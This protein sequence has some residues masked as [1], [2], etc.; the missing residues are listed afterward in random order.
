MTRPTT[1][2]ESDGKVTVEGAPDEAIDQKVA[3]LRLRAKLHFPNVL[4]TLTSIIQALALETLWSRVEAE[5]ETKGLAGIP[6]DSWLQVSA[7]LIAIMV[8]WIYYVQLVMRLVWVP[9]LTDSLIPFALGIAQF[10]EAYLLGKS[11]VAVWLL[12]F[13]MIFLLGLAA[14]HLTLA[15]ARRESENTAVIAGFMPESRIARFGPMLGSALL[16]ALLTLAVWIR[17]ATSTLALAILNLLMLGHLGLQ[18]VYWRSSVE[19]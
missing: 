6:L 17:P 12:P 18:G 3:V 8:L 11:N 14:W 5:I 2:N 7:L 16:L 13:P 1:P 10:T 19:G 9:S 15:R 4:L